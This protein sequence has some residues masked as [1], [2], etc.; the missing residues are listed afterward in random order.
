MKAGVLGNGQLLTDTFQGVLEAGTALAL[1]CSGLKVMQSRYRFAV[2]IAPA[3]LF[4]KL[5]KHY[6]VEQRMAP[7]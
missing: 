5:T 6:R 7:G 4:P 3:E 2:Y 1:C